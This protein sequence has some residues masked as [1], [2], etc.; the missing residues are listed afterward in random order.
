MTL[1]KIHEVT[2]STNPRIL[3]LKDIDRDIPDIDKCQIFSTVMKEGGDKNKN[4]F[5]KDEGNLFSTRIEYL[6]EKSPVIVIHQINEANYH[7]KCDLKIC[8][9]IIG[10]SFNFSKYDKYDFDVRFSGGKAPIKEVGEKF[11]A[12]IQKSC[13]ESGLIGTCMIKSYKDLNYDPAKSKVIT[14]L[15]FHEKDG[16]ACIHAYDLVTKKIV[17]PIPLEHS[18]IYYR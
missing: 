8:Y 10:H 17:R 18:Y 1:V 7:K 11:I 15:H 13:K 14:S 12:E 3:E 6:Q 16:K 2:F 9:V 4:L 5:S